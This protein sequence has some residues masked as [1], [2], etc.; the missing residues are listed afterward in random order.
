LTRNNNK[1]RHK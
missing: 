1:T